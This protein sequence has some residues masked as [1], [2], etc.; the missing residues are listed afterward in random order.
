MLND[1]TLTTAMLAVVAVIIT[2]PQVVH[3][4]RTYPLAQILAFRGFVVV[5]FGMLVVL[6]LLLMLVRPMRAFAASVTIVALLAGIANAGILVARGI[7]TDSLPEAT[8]TS[9]RVMT[10]NTKGEATSADEI[11]KTAV[12]MG[13]DIVALPETTEKTGVAVAVAMRELGHRM[14]VHNAH[15]PGWDARSTT[16][17]ISPK[18]GDYSVIESSE[19]GSSNT[20]TVPSAV[21]MPVDGSGPIV[22]AVHAVAPREADMQHWRDDL[23]WIADQCAT[24]D[25]ILIGDFNATVDHMAGLGTHGGTLGRCTDA[26]DATGNGAVGSWPTSLPALLGAPIDH[27]MVSGWKA[28]GSV[29]VRSKDSGASDHRP[30]VVQLEP[31]AAGG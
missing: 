23:Q 24:G 5:G 3:L 9:V 14:W 6:G 21:A 11:A 7:G 28:T 19:N 30:L 25:V 8:G 15:Y 22:V 16:I 4:E 13:A 12:A 26:A 18:L 29:V 10:W 20:S 17:L 31:A 27:V 2:W 1:V